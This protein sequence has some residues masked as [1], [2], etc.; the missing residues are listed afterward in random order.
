MIPRILHFIWIGNDPLPKWAEEN[1]CTWLKFNLGW[2]VCLWTN[3]QD[4]ELSR[5]MKLS[6]RSDSL[7]VY[8]DAHPNLGT[9]SDIL[10]LVVLRVFGGLYLDVDIE[11]W[12][13]IEH[14]MNR[15]ALLIEE[16]AA[17]PGTIG[18]S[19]MAFKAHHPFLDFC[20]DSLV[21]DAE[22]HKER[23]TLSTGPGFITRMHRA[24][25]SKI[26]IVHDHK[27]FFPF[28]WAGPRIIFPE[29]TIAVHQWRGSWRDKPTANTC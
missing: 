21:E 23:V 10:R 9:R 26:E 22:A 8:Y 7:V 15:E 11:C 12:G 14:W 3:R 16:S 19:L 4:R 2:R 5:W 28:D 13:S 29:T 1:I 27:V 25:L 18:N 24:A 17:T 20:L 6:N